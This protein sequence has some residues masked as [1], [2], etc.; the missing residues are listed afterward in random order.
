MKHMRYKGY[1]G[2]VE[3]SE[4]DDILHGKVLFIRALISYEGKEV[5]ALKKA[6]QEGVESYLALCQEK[7]IEPEKP[8]KGS[9]NVRLDE[10]LHRALAAK[11]SEEGLSLNQIAKKALEEYLS[12]S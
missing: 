9:F 6:F 4:E 12:V 3:Y 1:W 11:A 7:G 5:K 8:F 2:S 10:K